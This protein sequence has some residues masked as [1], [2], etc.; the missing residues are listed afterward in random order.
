MTI[1]FHLNWTEAGEQYEGK[2][3][4]YNE[5]ESRL[6]Q[7]KK[8]RIEE[9]SKNIGWYY[10]T[11]I[12]A[13]W[14]DDNQYTARMDI[15]ANPRQSFSFGEHIKNGLRWAYFNARNKSKEYGHM[16][17]YRDMM[18]GQIDILRQLKLDRWVNKHDIKVA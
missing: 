15:T 12:T 8:Q 10:K 17:F 13:F 16:G 5:L 7:I 6:F 14:G 3:L 2:D 1:K 11:N 18:Q 4:T 9:D